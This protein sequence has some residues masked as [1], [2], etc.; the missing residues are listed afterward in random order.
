MGQFVGNLGQVGLRR[1]FVSGWVNQGQAA[2]DQAVEA[3]HMGRL[4]A[5][6]VVCEGWSGQCC[7]L[8]CKHPRQIVCQGKQ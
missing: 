4:G 8:Q 6:Q 3:G 1:S 7:A 2:C 5:C